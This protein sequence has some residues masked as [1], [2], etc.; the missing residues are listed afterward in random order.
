MRAATQTVQN[1]DLRVTLWLLVLSAVAVVTCTGEVWFIAMMGVSVLWLLLRGRVA[2][3]LKFA[4]AYAALTTLSQLMLGVRG[5]ETL[6][7]FAN[8]GRHMLIPI[9]YASGIS[10]T[11]TGTLLA[12]FAKLRLPKAFGISTVVLL[13]YVPTISYELRAIRSSLKFRGSG[14]GF[15]HTLAHLPSNFERT[16]VPM[17]MRTTRIAEELSAAAMVRGV[18][19]NNAVESYEEVRFSATDAVVAGLFSAGIIAVWVL[20]KTLAGGLVG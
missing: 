1:V 8:I 10:N 5:L 6:W 19:L 15:W 14:V 2:Q 16:L 4:A 13:R 9:A 17:L 18:R 7:M 3:G 11:P 20:D 12:V